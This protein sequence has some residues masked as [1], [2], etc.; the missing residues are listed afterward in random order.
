MIIRVTL[1]ALLCWAKGTRSPLLPRRYNRKLRKVVRI[2]RLTTVFLAD[3]TPKTPSIG[4]CAPP[5]LRASSRLA[6]RLCGVSHI[7]KHTVSTPSM[8]GVNLR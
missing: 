2:I 4:W 7:R 5:I 1:E 3:M 6:T 8:T